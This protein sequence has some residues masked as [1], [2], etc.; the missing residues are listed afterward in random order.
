MY[1]GYQLKL[2]DWT[3][4]HFQSGVEQ[5]TDHAASAK[6]A[7]DNY[8]QEGKYLSAKE[9]EAEWFPSVKADVFISHSHKDEQ[10][11]IE[12]AGWLKQELGLKA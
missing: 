1:R 7:L 11:V 8:I 4:D 2:N 5:Y 10:L 3:H 12:I 9:L 6:I